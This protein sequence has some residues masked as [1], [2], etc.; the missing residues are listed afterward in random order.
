M[1]KITVSE[2]RQDPSKLEINDYIPYIKKIE[3]IDLIMGQVTT[4][5][6]GFYTIDSL[7][8]DRIFT[9]IIIE[10][11]SNL[12]LRE[13]DIDGLDG[14]DQ[15]IKYGLL[16]SV[17]SKFI[18]EWNEFK[19]I[20]NFRINDYKENKA[21]TRSYLNSKVESIYEFICDKIPKFVNSI[22]TDKIISK[23]SNQIE[24]LN[25]V[26]SLPVQK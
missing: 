5:N 1:D 20:L 9:Q 25:K 11:C 7:L 15:L 19:R 18:D 8:L 10:N 26:L 6:N 17:I 22:D 23:L 2:F 13:T 12:S 21:S 3:L 16:D 24:E 14:Y 4:N